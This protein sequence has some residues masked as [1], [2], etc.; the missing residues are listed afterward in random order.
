MIVLLSLLLLSGS[1]GVPVSLSIAAAS[2]KESSSSS[3]AA[4]YSIPRS[5]LPYHGGTH[6]R[7]AKVDIKT[8]CECR[9]MSEDDVD[10]VRRMDVRMKR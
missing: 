10:V 6:V 3:K 2:R 1:D 4:I 7:S 5:K 9:T 8:S